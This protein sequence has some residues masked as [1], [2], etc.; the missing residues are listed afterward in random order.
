VNEEKRQ[1][2]GYD[3]LCELQSQI[4]FAVAGKVRH[5]PGP[6]H[7]MAAA[8]H[9][10][11]PLPQAVEMVRSNESKLLREG[12]V[13]QLFLGREMRARARKDV[14]LIVVG[15]AVRQHRQ[16]LYVCGDNPEGRDRKVL[17]LLVAP[18][19][20]AHVTTVD[21]EDRDFGACAAAG[22]AEAD[23]NA[24]PAACVCALCA[25]TQSAATSSSCGSRSPRRRF[26]CC[27]LRP[28]RTSS[29][30]CGCSVRT[31]ARR[32]RRGARAR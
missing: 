30:G 23:G 31:R 5:A 22:G 1:L 20:L 27:R 10:G 24:A 4:D 25:R 28:W 18:A 11:G 21:V 2:E 29:R 12:R 14:Q 9:G 17:K 3:R 19:A 16:L 13:T 6:R 32:M 8:T 26:S 15:D 7:H